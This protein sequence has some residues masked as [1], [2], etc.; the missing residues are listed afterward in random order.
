MI[1]VEPLKQDSSWYRGATEAL[2]K[3][4]GGDSVIDV[5]EVDP[6]FF[7]QDV[8]FYGTVYSGSVRKGRFYAYFQF[9]TAGNLLD[10]YSGGPSDEY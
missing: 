2:I 1:N 4:G 6:D 9:D 10:D 8:L 7:E 5:V 3:L